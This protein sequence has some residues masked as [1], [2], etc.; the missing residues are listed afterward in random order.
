MSLIPVKPGSVTK[1]ALQK[2]LQFVYFIDVYD[3]N[4]VSKKTSYLH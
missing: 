2:P 4:T 3:F 1:E